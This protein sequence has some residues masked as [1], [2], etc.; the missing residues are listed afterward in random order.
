MKVFYKTKTIEVIKP[1]GTRV[2][3]LE[4]K[5]RYNNQES[6]FITFLGVI[7]GAISKI[8]FGS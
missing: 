8:W 6:V 3:T 7:I 2:R 4:R 5:I 1:C